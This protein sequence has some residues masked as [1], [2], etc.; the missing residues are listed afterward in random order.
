MAFT[1]YWNAVPVAIGGWPIDPA[2]FCLFW[3]CI[4]A[5]RSGAVTPSVAILAGLTHTRMP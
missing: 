2:A 1:G 4:A 5:T 3:V